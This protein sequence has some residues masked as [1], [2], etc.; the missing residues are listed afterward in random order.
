[1]SEVP[2]VRVDEVAGVEAVQGAAGDGAV[3]VH[4]PL[5]PVPLALV[6]GIVAAGLPRPS[7]PLPCAAMARATGLVAQLWAARF[8]ANPERHRPACR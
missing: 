7:C 4:V 8:G 5:P 6:R 1:M 2:G 3:A